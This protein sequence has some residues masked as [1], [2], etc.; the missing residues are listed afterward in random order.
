M[1]SLKPLKRCHLCLQTARRATSRQGSGLLGTARAS[2]REL[3]SRAPPSWPARPLQGLLEALAVQ[4]AA[5]CQVRRLDSQQVCRTEQAGGSARGRG[6]APRQCTALVSSRFTPSR[7]H[8]SHLLPTDAALGFLDRGCTVTW[9]LVHCQVPHLH[10]PRQCE[11]CASPTLGHD[12]SIAATLHCRTAFAVYCLHCHP[13]RYRQMSQ[14]TTHRHADPAQAKTI[15]LQQSCTAPHHSIQS[16]ACLPGQSTAQSQAL[17]NV[18]A[19]QCGVTRVL[20][21]PHP[22]CLATGACRL[23]HWLRRGTT[24]LG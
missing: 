21:C 2:T 24:L 8:E 10:R 7:R 11:Q 18:Q 20:R 23:L 17:G 22:C 12:A 14:L 1:T 16:A 4:G 5:R 19:V 9:C 6:A 3:P 13:I 15:A